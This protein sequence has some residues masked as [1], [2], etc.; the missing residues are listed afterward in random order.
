MVLMY[1]LNVLW[2]AGIR[3][4]NFSFMKVNLRMKPLCDAQ[5]QTRHLISWKPVTK[6]HPRK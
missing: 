6:L 2:D 3:E 4:I 5:R 1:S